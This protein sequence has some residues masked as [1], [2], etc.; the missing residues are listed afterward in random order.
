ME[1]IELGKRV[2]VIGGGGREHALAWKLLQSSK[3]D[4]LYMAP[5]N[6]GTKQIAENTGITPRNIK[7]LLGITGLGRFT[8]VDLTVVGPEISLEDGIV[9]DFQKEGLNIF[10][11]NRF[12]AQIETSKAFAKQ[13]MAE[14]GIPTAAFQIFQTPDKALSYV[15][16]QS[17]PIV[18]KA[19]GLA[20]GKGVFICKNLQ[21]A[22][23]AL[24][25]IF[26]DHSEVVIEEFLE[27]PEISIHA[28]CDGENAILMPPS[29]DY[30]RLLTGN[31]GPNTGG[32]G[33]YASVPWVTKELMAQIKKEIVDPVLKRFRE[34]GNPYVGLLYPGLVITEDGPKVL[35]FNARFGDPETQ[36]YM[37][38]L[39]T[40]LYDILEACIE[41]KLKD[42]RIEWKR[43]FAVCI[44]LASCLYP[45]HN[46]K[47]WIIRGLE[48]VEKGVV[49]FHS[50]TFYESSLDRLYIDGG[51]ILGIT[52]TGKTLEEARNK[53]YE[54]VEIVKFRG[55]RYREDIAEKVPKN[56]P[57][58]I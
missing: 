40:D 21:E 57:Y 32:M 16:T 3:V 6:G 11:P 8:R 38:L 58:V 54:A 52:A 55:I 49:V 45:Y 29:Q 4:K 7:G 28:F 42:F 34:L 35:E 2:L 53:A 27:G 39:K 15:R 51:R 23:D 48:K 36:S 44:I 17:F 22:E 24:N 10:G 31:R 19:S 13:F 5:G 37:R 14:V 1:V 33:S 25:K 43:G 9:D 56:H 41:G 20:G 46:Q 26:H 30:K 18:I 50:G 12:P 47:G